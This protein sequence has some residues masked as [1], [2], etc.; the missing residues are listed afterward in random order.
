MPAA[1]KGLKK[2]IVANEFIQRSMAKGFRIDRPLVVVD[3][4][5]RDAELVAI[6][7]PATEFGRPVIGSTAFVYEHESFEVKAD[8]EV[9]TQVVRI[10][11]TVH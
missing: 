8:G 9:P 5:P 2:V 1:L 7:F 6:E 11:E 10:T 3:G 4:V